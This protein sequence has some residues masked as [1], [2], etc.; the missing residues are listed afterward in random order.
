M[1]EL[2]AGV[3]PIEEQ[4]REYIKIVGLDRQIRRGLGPSQHVAQ[5]NCVMVLNVNLD[6]EWRPVHVKQLVC[7][8][9]YNGSLLKRLD[10]AWSGCFK[11]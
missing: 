1:H 9:R 8:G 4:Y 11:G 3:P 5:N 10:L 7:I 2:E 6:E